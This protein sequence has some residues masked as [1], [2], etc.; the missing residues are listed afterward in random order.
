[1]NRK[2]TITDLHQRLLLAI[3]CISSLVFLGSC[4]AAD[5]PEVNTEYFI[6]VQA[7]ARIYRR[8]GLPPAS[9]EQLIGKTTQKMMTSAKEIAAKHKHQSDVDQRTIDSEV[10]VAC[11]EIYREYAETGFKD[12]AI[13]TATLYRG[14]RVNGI[15]KQSQSLKTYRF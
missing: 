3:L 4:T 7:K 13:C 6:V 10:L 5:E 15:I 2:S 12:N 9:K 8:G 1:M 11:D 14:V